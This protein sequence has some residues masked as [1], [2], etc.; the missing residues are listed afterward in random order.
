M[1]DWFR[2]VLGI[3]TDRQII[4]AVNG[5]P[6]IAKARKALGRADDILDALER[7]DVE[8]RTRPR[9]KQT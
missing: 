5:E 2:G 8:R 7:L 3:K 4:E 9:R 6:T 1:I